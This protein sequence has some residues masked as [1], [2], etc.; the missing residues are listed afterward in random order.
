MGRFN[1][2]FIISV[3]GEKLVFCKRPFRSLGPHLLVA[4]TGMSAG[5]AH[6]YAGTFTDRWRRK[7][8]LLVGI[9]ILTKVNL[10]IKRKS[11]TPRSYS[12]AAK[13]REETADKGANFQESA[14]RAARNSAHLRAFCYA[15]E[16]AGF[17]E[18]TFASQK[19]MSALPPKADM[20]GA[21][22]DI[23]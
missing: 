20:C 8:L 12:R 10:A 21:A 19:V 3:P 7:F 2:K 17:A 5:G 15:G 16:H 14:K 6:F 9:Q 23:C 22:R 18:S 4:A 11:K 13:C 1:S